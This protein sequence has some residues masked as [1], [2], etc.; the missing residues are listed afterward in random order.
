MLKTLVTVLL[1]LYL[2]RLCPTA[3]AE[4]TMQV[5]SFQEALKLPT[6]D[7]G[8]PSSGWYRT[9]LFPA[10]SQ[11]HVKLAECMNAAHVPKNNSIRDALSTCR[12]DTCIPSLRVVGSWWSLKPSTW[13]LTVV[14]QASLS[15][16]HQIEAQC[17][18]FRGPLSVALYTPIFQSPTTTNQLS[19]T[20]L[21][22]LQE[23]YDVV[24][25]FAAHVQAQQ[26]TCSLSITLVYEVS[27]ATPWNTTQQAFDA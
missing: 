20:N 5:L 2:L 9:A 27:L 23:Q 1:Q 17:K 22:Q 7:P 4:A 10:S 18:S 6:H 24:A 13:P 25:K 3:S 12:C 15:R 11:S 26:H 21:A 14:T 8:Q 16:L 19:A